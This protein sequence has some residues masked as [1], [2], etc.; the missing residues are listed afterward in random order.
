MKLTL[1]SKR[2]GVSLMAMG[3]TVGVSVAQDDDTPTPITATEVIATSFAPTVPAAGTVFSR[4]ESQIT[5]GMAGRLNWVAEPGDTIQAGSPVATFDC[6]ML[7]IQRERQLAEA[8]R[9]KINLDALDSEI[10]RLTA[11]LESSVISE[12]QLDRTT[13]SR[14]LAKSDLR[15]AKI[16]I[17]ETDSQLSRCAVLAP[18]SGVVTVQ[19]RNAGEDVERSTMLAAMTDTENLEVRASVPIRY[20]PRMRTG[21][22][23]QVR[24]NELQIESRIRRIVPAANSQS[25]TFE[26]RLELPANAKDLV[27]SGQLVSTRLPLIPNAAL[28]VPRDS[29]VLREEG[30]FV[31]RIGSDATVERVAVEVRDATGD[32]IAIQGA[33][34]SGDVIAVRG[35]EALD[36]GEQVAVQSDT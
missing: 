15:I 8:D 27:A 31:M 18:F 24:M 16:S 36:D 33:L 11:V 25:Q 20:L 3:M 10:K 30:T 14:D 21:D 12:L 28:T 9:A 5:A 22:V 34:Q 2:L 13:A 23:A 32:S 4:N 17:R 29:V 7:E 26:V 1:T 35:A 6:E 19:A